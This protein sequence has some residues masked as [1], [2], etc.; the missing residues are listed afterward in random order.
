M[1]DAESETVRAAEETV[2]R[3][4]ETCQKSGP[5]YSQSPRAVAQVSRTSKWLLNAIQKLC[6]AHA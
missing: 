6:R 1:N 5:L 3:L 4:V 2:G